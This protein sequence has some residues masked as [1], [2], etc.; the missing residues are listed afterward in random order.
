MKKHHHKACFGLLRQAAGRYHPL[1]EDAWA[2][3]AGLFHVKH[4]DEGEFYLLEGAP[5]QQVAFVCEGLVRCY[6]TGP[7]GKEYNKVFFHESTIAAAFSSLLRR[8]PSN[9]SLQ[10]LEDSV[11]LEANFFDIVDLFDAF[12][13]IERFYRIYLEQNWVLRKQERELRFAMT[14]AEARYRAFLNEYPGLDQRISQYHIASHL[15]IT[16]TQLSRI[17]ARRTRT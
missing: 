17:R 10:A 9:L 2:A 6:F 13:D 7:D 12:R 16:P 14:D 15:G 1:P 11:L 8:E 4:L 5:T 3:F